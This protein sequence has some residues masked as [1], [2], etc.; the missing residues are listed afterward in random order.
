MFKKYSWI[1]DPL[2]ILPAFIN[3]S[4][5]LHSFLSSSASSVNGSTRVIHNVKTTPNTAIASAAVTSSRL[6]NAFPR[7]IYL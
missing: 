6:T 3:S 2:A 5:F 1:W 4:I 7:G